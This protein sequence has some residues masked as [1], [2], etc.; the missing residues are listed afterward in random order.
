MVETSWDRPKRGL[1]EPVRRGRG[2]LGEVL[3][4]SGV[5]QP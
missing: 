5:I 2:A 4:C 3:A 1:K